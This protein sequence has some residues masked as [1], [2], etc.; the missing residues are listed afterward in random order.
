MISEHNNSIDSMAPQWLRGVLCMLISS[1]LIL[2]F[3]GVNSQFNLFRGVRISS[4]CPST[5]L[6]PRSYRRRRE[7]VPAAVVSDNLQVKLDI[8]TGPATNERRSAEVTPLSDIWNLAPA[9]TSAQA[10]ECAGARLAM[11]PASAGTLS[12]RC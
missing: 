10:V 5:T 2:V 1:V 6:L 7:T 12:L 9:I 4:S 11:H 8:G 3:A